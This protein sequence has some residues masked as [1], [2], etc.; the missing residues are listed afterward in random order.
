ME[1][2]PYIH[3]LFKIA[4]S[5]SNGLGMKNIVELHASDVSQSSR[6]FAMELRCEFWCGNFGSRFP[7]IAF[8]AISLPLNEVLKSS[9]V[10]TTVKYFLYFPL[11]FSVDDYR[12]WVV[13]HLASC[14]WV[15]WGRSKLHYVEYW[16]ELLHPMWQSQA[17]G[18]RSDP[19]FYYKGAESSMREFLQRAHSLDV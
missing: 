15:V 18:H 11:Q 5:W 19:L 4:T 3:P 7:G 13:L 16:I 9:P 8:A 12:R 10:P 2:S 6:V 14:N 17:I 1:V